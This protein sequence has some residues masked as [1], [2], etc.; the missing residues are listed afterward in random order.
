M[1]AVHGSAP[2]KLFITGEYAVLDQAPALLTAVDVRAHCRLEPSGSMQ[3]RIQTPPISS[4][5]CRLRV[6]GDCLHWEDEPVRLFEAAWQALDE[7]RRRVLAAQGW[8]V[9][10]DS[11]AFF[12]KERKLGLGSSAATLVAL[13]GALW[14]ASGELPPEAEAFEAAAKAHAGWQGAGSGADISVALVGGTLLY[15][16]NP[17]IAAPVALPE[18]LA[19]VPVWTGQAASTGDFLARLAVFEQS[20]PDVFRERFAVLEQHAEAAALAVSGGELQEFTEAFTDCGAAMRALGDAAGLDIWS[21]AHREIAACVD[22]A[23]GFYK[24]SG[25]GG[26]DIGL[27]LLPR[28]DDAALQRL[29][30]SLSSAG[31]TDLPLRFGARGLHVE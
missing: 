30:S 14:R 8:N 11:S 13:L 28:G 1:T 4:V 15:R 10:L 18:A 23:G 5:P 20:S 6:E 29:K 25:A 19:L 27:A 2:G 16:R 7:T 24:P 31:F 17:R 9:V 21:A 26:G 3:W 22:V 12:L